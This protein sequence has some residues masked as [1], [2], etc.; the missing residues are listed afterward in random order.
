MN[1]K[2][3]LLGV[4]I[5]AVLGMAVGLFLFRERNYI[6][7]MAV[8]GATPLAVKADVGSGISLKIFGLTKRTYHF[9]HRA[10][11]AMAPVYL[12]TREVSPAGKFEG[13]YRYSGVSVLHLL[14]GVAPQKPQNA[15]FDKP[16]D[17]V[18]TFVSKR[19]ERRHF[20]YGELTMTDDSSPVILA[21]RRDPLVPAS[22]D[23]DR[24]YP[25]NLHQGPLLGLRL[26]CPAEPDT[27]RYL[28]DVQ[29][30][31]FRD[32]G[33]AHP[34]L[35]V[36]RKGEKC[37]SAGVT[38]IRGDRLAP[39]ITAGVAETVVA[40][41]VRTGHGQGFKGISTATGY[42][43]R[44]LLVANFPGCGQEDWFLF[45]ACD[46]YRAIFSG[47]EIFV[48]EAGKRM[49]LLATVDG[50]PLKTGLSMGPVADYF[51]DRQVWGLT[52]IAM[53]DRSL[54]VGKSGL[55]QSE[56]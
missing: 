14:E 45:V 13:T 44:D 54:L 17:I 37:V 29:Q 8:T 27:S 33:V 26:V 34:A 53:L 22:K 31:E 11:N 18:V 25:H 41:W 46:G 52:H 40:D 23:L 50:K 38:T 35:P 55:N 3:V 20:S 7:I 43:L 39:L 51:I 28:D 42:K 15:L 16:H 47:R 1:K 36:T 9:D 5:G 10:L 2:H 32:P 49:M 30:I 21:Y 6:R 56:K 4:A 19:G 48:T 12:R 24:P